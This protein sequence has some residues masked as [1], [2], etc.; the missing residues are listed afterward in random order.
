MYQLVKSLRRL[1]KGEE[2]ERSGNNA[3]CGIPQ[4]RTGLK[5][6]VKKNELAETNGTPG[7]LPPMTP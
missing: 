1:D 4:S 5:E 7:F 2:R 3:I 6:L